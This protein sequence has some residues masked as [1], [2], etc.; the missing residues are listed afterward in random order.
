MYRKALLLIIILL[1]STYTYAK[2]NVLRP[3][4]GLEWGVSC[5]FY[6]RD[7]ILYTTED[8]FLVELEDIASNNHVN[9]SLTAYG[10][11]RYKQIETSVKIGY[12]GV[13]KNFRVIPIGLRLS[14]FFGKSADN[15]LFANLES[16]LG[17]P[18]EKKYRES[19]NTNL[20]LGYRFHIS[21]K[22]SIDY[23]LSFGYLAAQPLTFYNY[24]EL[25]QIK[26]GNIKVSEL[27][28]LSVKLSTALNF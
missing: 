9:G 6:N 8:K 23:K 11:F 15:G 20:G 26:P 17:I 21:K 7:Y 28:V 19:I 4:Y 18:M 22:F 10:G 24:H 1:S 16:S 12:E 3:V 2:D 5:S 25:N 27:D 14:Y 13:S